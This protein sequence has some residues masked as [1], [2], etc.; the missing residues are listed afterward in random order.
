MRNLYYIANLVYTQSTPIRNR[1]RGKEADRAHPLPV[2]KRARHHRRTQSIR[3]APLG[4]R[5][6]QR[7][8]L[9]GGDNIERDYLS[10][11]RNAAESDPKLLSAVSYCI[12][13]QVI[14]YA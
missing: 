1:P 8:T 2:G 9:C 7:E 10:L 5:N 11:K 4:A 6:E 14:E 3:P 13:D 12:S